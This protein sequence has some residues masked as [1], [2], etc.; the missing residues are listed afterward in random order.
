MPWQ[1]MVS[2]IGFWIDNSQ[3]RYVCDTNVGLSNVIF[4]DQIN[5]CS[6]H[7]IRCYSGCNE[8]L[9]LLAPNGG[10]KKTSTQI[11]IKHWEQEMMNV[12][13]KLVKS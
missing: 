1:G 5:W 13:T 8:I 6:T 2:C 3:H 10:T 7:F 11:I 12:R 4:Q 9:V